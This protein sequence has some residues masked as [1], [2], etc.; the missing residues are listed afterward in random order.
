METLGT[1][2]ILP[3]S[4]SGSREGGCWGAG[5]AGLHEQHTSRQILYH[6]CFDF[7]VPQTQ[8]SLVL[9]G[10]S[11]MVMARLSADYLFIGEYLEEGNALSK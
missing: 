5:E 6:P 4:G 9:F 1:E 8:T 3:S 10:L 2:Q 7:L 11:H